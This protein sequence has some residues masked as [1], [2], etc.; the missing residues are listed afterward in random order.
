G[1]RVE[2]LNAEC[3]ALLQEERELTVKIAHLKSLARIEEMARRKLGMVDPT[4]A[5][6]VLV[7]S[8]RHLSPSPAPPKGKSACVQAPTVRR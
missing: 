2:Q 3:S 1:Y 6:I 8:V 4:P 7:S 5:Q